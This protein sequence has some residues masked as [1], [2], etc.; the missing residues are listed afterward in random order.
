MPTGTG[1]GSRAEHCAIDRSF[2]QPINAGAGLAGVANNA[3]DEVAVQVYNA[4]HLVGEIAAASSAQAQSIPQ[5]DNAMGEIN[6]IA[7]QETAAP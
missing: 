6:K 4:P 2:N 5:I 7:P 1:R 3:F